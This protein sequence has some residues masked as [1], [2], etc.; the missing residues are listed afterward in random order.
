VTSNTMGTQGKLIGRMDS[1]SNLLA[2]LRPRGKEVN[3]GCLVSNPEQL[4]EVP[5]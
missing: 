1:L 3:G 4:A 2:H 5:I